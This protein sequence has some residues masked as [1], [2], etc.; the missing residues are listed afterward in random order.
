MGKA[1]MNYQDA[2]HGYQAGYL[3]ALNHLEDKIRQIVK[4]AQRPIM[5]DEI[6]TGLIVSI[7]TS[8]LIQLLHDLHASGTEHLENRARIQGVS[9]P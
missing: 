1:A 7:T 8:G 6:S 4:S 2:E 5:N 3:T 9:A